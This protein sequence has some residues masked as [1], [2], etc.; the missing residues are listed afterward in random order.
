MIFF[1]FQNDEFTKENQKG[2][3]NSSAKYKKS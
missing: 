1:P 2:Y 3:S